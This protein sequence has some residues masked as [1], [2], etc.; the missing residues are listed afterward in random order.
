MFKTCSILALSSLFIAL[1]DQ[2]QRPQQPVKNGR[3]ESYD[4]RTN[5]KLFDIRSEELTPLADKR[6]RIKKP[7]GVVYL[8]EQ[9]GRAR[10]I[11]FT[12]EE[13]TF[14][15]TSK[16]LA[17][18]KDV[19]LQT[20]DGESVDAQDAVVTLNREQ[21]QQKLV[22]RGPFKMIRMQGRIEGV[23]LDADLELENYTVARDAKIRMIDQAAGTTTDVASRG[24]LSAR[25]DKAGLGYDTLYLHARE[26]ATLHRTDKNG[27]A[28]VEADELTTQ[29]RCYKGK[30]QESRRTVQQEVERLH[31]KGNVM[32]RDS[33]G[34]QSRCDDLRFGSEADVVTMKGAPVVVA[35]QQNELRADE[36]QLDRV[37]NLLSCR[38]NVNARMKDSD[39]TGDRLKVQLVREPTGWTAAQFEATGNV[40]V[41]KADARIDCDRFLWDNRFETGAVAGRPATVTLEGARIRAPLIT[42]RG[43]A[44]CVSGPKSVVFRREIVTDR[45]SNQAP[46]ATEETVFATSRGDMVFEGNR[47]RMTDRAFLSGK[48]VRVTGDVIR[49]E[50][51][52]DR[53]LDRVT[54]FSNLRIRTPAEQQSTVIY[55]DSMVSRGDLLTIFGRPDAY[56]VD[57]GQSLRSE[58]LTFDRATG[59]FA[60]S[61]TRRTGRIVISRRMAAS[62]SQRK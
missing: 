22:V 33:R 20:A 7:A 43:E 1:Q 14:D 38:N 15:E 16:V 54:A 24:P 50:L 40:V 19:R 26:K 52:D 21:R 32:M 11:E 58:V 56:V 29:V 60:A 42:I 46:S 9:D 4:T 2:D 6:Y 27:E 59:R 8:K 10:R 23:D 25:E 37:T 48:D 18:T 17:L 61:N 5:E 28:W 13:G 36:V 55:G 44:L 47:V 49:V 51:T 12:A 39:V 3:L 53:K 31:A 35:Q 45:S 62:G 41:R 57:E 34:A 30:P